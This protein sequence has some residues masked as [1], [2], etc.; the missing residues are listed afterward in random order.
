MQFTF[1]VGIDVSKATLDFSVVTDAAEVMVF[2][3]ANT[4]KAIKTG[5]RQLKKLNGFTMEQ[6]VFCMEYTGVY[7]NHVCTILQQEG[8]I[9]WLEKAIHIKR[10]SGLQRGKTDKIDAQRIAF[11]AFRNRDQVKCWHPTRPVLIKLKRLSVLRERLLIIRSQLL[12]PVTE[13]ALFDDPEVSKMM[14]KHCRASANAV[15]ADIKAVDKQIKQLIMD[16]PALKQIFELV[17]SVVGIGSVIACTMILTTNEFKSIN[18][19]KK[20][21]CYAGVVPFEHSSGSSVR[22]KARVSHFANKEVKRLLH[23]AA[24]SIIRYDGELKSYW[25]RKIEQGKHKMII[26]NA[27]RNKLIQRVFAVVKRGT[28]FERIYVNALA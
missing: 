15:N 28:P 3:T 6:S 2:Q 27:I 4:P 5:L 16:D 25:L 18:D 22:G 7:N 12:K 24:L 23:L 17:T 8:G 26:L 9:I 1:F 13:S 14:K 19:P 10:S 21:A 11:F 20:Y